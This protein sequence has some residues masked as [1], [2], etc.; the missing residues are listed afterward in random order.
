[1]SK[2]T[3]IIGLIAIVAVIAAIISAWYENRVPEEEP[4]EI[5]EE[6]PE[7]ILEPEPEEILEPEPEQSAVNDLLSEQQVTIVPPDKTLK[8]GKK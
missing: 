7:E 8:T 3:L 4:E 1:M 2:R 5:L 6:E